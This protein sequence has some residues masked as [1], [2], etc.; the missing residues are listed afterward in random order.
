MASHLIV[1][2]DIESIVAHLPG[3]RAELEAT[4]DAGAARAE[5]ILQLRHKETNPA[6]HPYIEVT[7]GTKLDYFVNLVD[8]NPKGSAASIEFGRSG[9]RRGATQGVRALSGAF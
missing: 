5:A 6:P 3:V 4:A 9:G 7:Q 8:P 1:A 2:S